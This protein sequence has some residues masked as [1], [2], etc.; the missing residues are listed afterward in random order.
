MI[1][2]KYYV[3]TREQAYE[4]IRRCL[5]TG[6]L[7]MLVFTPPL[8]CGDMLLAIHELKRAGR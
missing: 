7:Y 8:V 6:E 5:D 4:I 2:H 1:V 3:K